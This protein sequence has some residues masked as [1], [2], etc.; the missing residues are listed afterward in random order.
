[1][2]VKTNSA[3]AAMPWSDHYRRSARYNRWMNAQLLNAS[4]SLP[5][6]QQQ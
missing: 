2:Y 6:E 3:E 4:L 1:V 5:R